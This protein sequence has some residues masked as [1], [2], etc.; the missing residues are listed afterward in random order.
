MKKYFILAAAAAMFAACSN[1]DEITQTETPNERIPLLIGAAYSLGDPT[2]TTMRGTNVDYQTT[3]LESTNILGIYIRKN[4]SKA[5]K[6]STDTYEVDNIASSTLSSPQT[7]N[8]ID[9]VDVTPTSSLYYPDAKEQKI[10]IYAYAPTSIMS[11]PAAT[12]IGDFNIDLS[13]H[14]D[15]GTETGYMANDIIWGMEGSTHEISAKAYSDADNTDGTVSGA[16]VGT[17][18]DARVII[19]M[20]HKCSKIIIKLL[21]DGMDASK[22]NGAKVNF[23]VD[24]TKGKMDLSDGTITTYTGT[25]GENYQKSQKIIMTPSSGVTTE[26]QCAAIILPQYINAKETDNTTP[27]NPD[28]NDHSYRLIEI[29]LTDGSTYTYVVNTVKQFESEKQYTYNITVTASGLKITTTVAD[30]T[31]GFSGTEGDGIAELE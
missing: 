16:Y 13:S 30:W 9:Y 26:H 22:L 10:D 14:T 24:Y 4:G 18:T 31:A 5:A 19:P 2:V 15:Q 11:S 17:G 23:M 3:A 27:L 20:K 12:T 7:R 6:V 28:N 1:T 29:E 21:A 8:T 25:T